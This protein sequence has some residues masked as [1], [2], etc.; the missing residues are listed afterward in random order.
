MTWL[1]CGLCLSFSLRLRVREGVRDA[2]VTWLIHIRDLAHP[3]TSGI[4]FGEALCGAA[5]CKL[6]QRLSLERLGNGSQVLYIYRYI[7]TYRIYT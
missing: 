3:Y 7:Y 1:V 2:S 5:M 4:S 6:L